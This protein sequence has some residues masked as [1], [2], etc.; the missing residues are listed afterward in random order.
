M[1]CAG[2]WM[3]VCVV[4][5]FITQEVVRLCV[6]ALVKVTLR[7][8]HHY[9]EPEVNLIATWQQSCDLENITTS[10]I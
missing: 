3:V 4:A 6:V 7:L 10:Q 5:V 1:R 2:A 9:H 8:H